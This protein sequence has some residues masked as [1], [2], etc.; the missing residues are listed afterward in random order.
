MDNR[1]IAINERIPQPTTLP[2]GVYQGIW[3]GSKIE[4]RYK[5]KTY[6]LT[7]FEGVR[8]FNIKVVVE[9]ENGEA[10]FKEVNN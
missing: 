9:I 8:G 5:D 1:I 2:D 4:L 7:T 3:G 10:T 6:E